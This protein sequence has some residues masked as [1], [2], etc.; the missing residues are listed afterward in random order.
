MKAFGKLTRG[1]ALSIIAAGAIGSMTGC[2][3]IETGSVG[4]L[5]H[6]GGTIDT[7]PQTGVVMTVFDSVIAHVDTTEARVKLNDLRPADSKGVQLEDL[8]VVLSIKLNGE[9]V[10][11]FFINTKELDTFKDESGRE[12]TT[13]GLNVVKNLASHAINEAT[14]ARQMSTLAANLP[15]Y[16][17]EILAQVQKELESGYPGVFQVVRVN[18]NNIKL[19]DSVAKQASAMANLEME[20]ERLDKEMSLTAKRETMA[21]QAALID[22]KALKTAIETTRLTA[23]QLTAWKNAKSYAEQAAAMGSKAAPVLDARAPAPK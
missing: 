5:K 21:S 17:K 7:A 13:V 19:P 14:K 6:W 15:T 8:D 9:K 20:T 18:V 23:E 1:I 4:I 11:S 2:T 16:E 10:P 22:A 3:R 12:V